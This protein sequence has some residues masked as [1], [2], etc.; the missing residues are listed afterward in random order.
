[1]SEHRVLD[2]D[3]SPPQKQQKKKKAKKAKVAPAR[4]LKYEKRSPL[5][6]QPP[7]QS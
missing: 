7:N 5:F 1:M 6:I 3:S 2:I 4:H